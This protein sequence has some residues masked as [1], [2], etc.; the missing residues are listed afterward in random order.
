[1]Y[2]RLTHGPMKPFVIIG[3]VLLLVTTAAALIGIVREEFLIASGDV[4]RRVVVGA[5]LAF[6]LFWLILFVVRMFQN[7]RHHRQ[8]SGDSRDVA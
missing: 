7:V 5:I 3:M 1:M 2:W 4:A 8:A 6:W